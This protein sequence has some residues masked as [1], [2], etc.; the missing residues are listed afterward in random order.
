MPLF[1]ALANVHGKYH[2]DVY[3]NGGDYFRAKRFA[4]RHNLNVRFHG[5][6]PFAK[7]QDAI[8]NSHLDV[9]VSYNFDTFGMT[10]IEAEAAG[11]PVFFC[12]PDMR[13]IVPKGSYI[14]SQNET[15]SARAASLNDLLKNPDQIRQMSEIMLK[16]REEVLIS[17]RIKILEKYMETSATH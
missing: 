10:L 5:N 4:K 1:R 6:T 11:V 13:E 3:G 14:M 16:H 9:L 12:D 8:L 17:K 7:I 2:L 15:P